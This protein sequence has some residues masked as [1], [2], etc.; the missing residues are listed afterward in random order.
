M[1]TTIFGEAGVYSLEQAMEPQ[2]IL[3]VNGEPVSAP[4]LHTAEKAKL[5]YIAQVALEVSGL[6]D[7][8]IPQGVPALKSVLTIA[9][10]KSTTGMADGDVRMVRDPV[11]TGG[12]VSRVGLFVYDSSSTLSETVIPGAVDGYVVVLPN[13][14]VGR[15]LNVAAGLGWTTGANAR[16]LPRGQKRSGIESNTGPGSDITV[17]DS[18]GYFATGIELGLSTE[19]W[20]SSTALLVAA[21][22]SFKSGA[23][24]SGFYFQIEVSVG[25]GAWAQ[26][27]GSRRRVGGVAG[28]NDLETAAHI[29]AAFNMGSSV[30]HAFRV[31]VDTGDSDTITIY[32]D[33]QMTATWHW[34]GV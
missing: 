14:G 3:P 23:L 17:S 21:N 6:R 13:S 20:R 29:Q 12:N 4:I 2:A 7:V 11:V 30:E 32:R 18:G 10:L 26:V 15:W 28:A 33:W 16:F 8:T 22:F 31:T 25:G 5:D 27:P 9:S 24:A 19:L 34:D 1:T